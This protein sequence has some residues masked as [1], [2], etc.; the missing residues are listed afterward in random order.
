MCEFLNFLLKVNLHIHLDVIDFTKWKYY[1]SG[2]DLLFNLPAMYNPEKKQ[3]N[4]KK[5][6]ELAY[7]GQLM[8]PYH[9]QR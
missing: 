1:I 2:Y 9:S 7:P 8:A 5:V 6:N 4:S 3:Q